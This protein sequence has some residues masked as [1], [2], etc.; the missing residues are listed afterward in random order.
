MRFQYQRD[1]VFN[2]TTYMH[3]LEQMAR[4]YHGTKVH[5]LQD[6]A[7]YHKDKN[8]WQWFKDNRSWLEVYNLPP[9]SPELNAQE[10]LW[11]YTRKS[12][13]HNK[14]FNSQDE[15]YDTLLKVFTNIQKQPSLIQGY[16]H[17]F[18]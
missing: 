15:I 4:S 2:A 14:C 12:G 11:K 8:V 16:L 6:N 5:Y 3:F 9:Y 1:E 17:P 18:L 10:P 13:T 7:P